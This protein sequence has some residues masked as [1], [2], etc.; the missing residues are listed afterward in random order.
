MAKVN[1]TPEKIQASPDAKIVNVVFGE[2][3]QQGRVLYQTRTKR[4]EIADCTLTMEMAQAGGIALN[5]GT[6]GQPGSV[7]TRGDLFCDELSMENPVYILSEEGQLCPADELESGHYI[8][9]IGAAV[10]PN[11]LRVGIIITNSQAVNI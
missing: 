3:V 6:V 4:W 1:F 10:N 9:I 7:L 11:L 8:T 5:S 2:T